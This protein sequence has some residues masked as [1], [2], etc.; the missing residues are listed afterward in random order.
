MQ[1]SRTLRRLPFPLA[2]W[3][4]RRGVMDLRTVVSRLDA[5]APPALAES[6]DNVGLLVEPSPPH[7]VHRLLLTNDLTEDVLE[8]AVGMAAD[9]V[10]SYHPPIFKALKRVTSGSWKE[11]LVVKALEG[12][13]AVY[14]PHT[15]YDALPDGVNDWLGRAVGPCTSVPLRLSS[16]LS[17]PGGFAHVLEFSHDPSESPV[18]RLKS[19]PGVRLHPSAVREDGDG[20]ARVRVSCSRDALPQV[21]AVLTEWPRAY[22]SVELLN[23]QKPPLLDTGMGRL[24][25][26]TESVSIATALERIKAHL[27][28]RHLRLAL[29]RGK[30][31]ESSVSTVAVCAGSGSSI[32]SGV[33]AD[34]YLTGEMS[35]HDV[36]DVVAEGRS[37]VLCE[38]SNSERGFLK[39]L[40]GKIQ[41]MLEGKVEVVVSQA[42]RDPLQVV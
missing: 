31:L 12:R 32:L 36:L 26:L 8:E 18:S 25:T 23:L 22:S 38:H 37:V 35:H 10:L 14:S 20:A 6:W 4:S 13:L 19:L 2:R 24:C 27:D 1:L 17:H 3:S 30:T 21:L 33:P 11:R 15:A 5:F 28:L 16:W 9:L 40:R 34:L 41:E 39:E 29:G 7:L 42:D